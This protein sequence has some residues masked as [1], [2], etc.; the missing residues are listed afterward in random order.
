MTASAVQVTTCATTC[1]CLAAS[2]RTSS[3]AS[4]ARA[5]M[6]ATNR[7]RAHC[8]N[9]VSRI[10]PSTSDTITRPSLRAHLLT[11]SSGAIA[12]VNVALPFGDDDLYRN[13]RPYPLIVSFKHAAPGEQQRSGQQE[14]PGHRDR[15]AGAGEAGQQAPQGGQDRDGGLRA[16]RPRGQ[17]PGDQL[18]RGLLEPDGGEY[19]VED[20][21]AGDQAVLESHDQDQAGQAGAEEGKPDD[22]D[23]AQD[24]GGE[25]D[26]VLPEP[27][28]QPGGQPGTD[29][30][31]GAGDREREP[32]L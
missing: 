13:G 3:S 30:A 20:A 11:S 17:R 22:P 2:E 1:R 14:H 26:P 25:Q 4:I 21:A 12:P 31:A 23:R 29:Q 5:S 6:Y 15:G 7:S 18:R 27:R 24:P 16:D 19:R 28:D 32:V 8:A 10:A 9:R